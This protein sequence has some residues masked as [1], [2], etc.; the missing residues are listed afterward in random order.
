M[1]KMLEQ[2]KRY[3]REMF[4]VYSDD[5]FLNLWGTT[6]DADGDDYT[7]IYIWELREL[8]DK[9]ADYM[10]TLDKY[11]IFQTEESIS[12]F[13]LMGVDALGEVKNIE[14]ANNIAKSMVT[15]MRTRLSMNGVEH[16]LADEEVVSEA[17]I[18]DGDMPKTYVL[19]QEDGYSEGDLSSKVVA[20][21]KYESKL[22]TLCDDRVR[23]I[24]STSRFVGF[25]EREGIVGAYRQVVDEIRKLRITW[26]IE[27][28]LE[29]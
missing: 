29:V 21:S 11:H 16:P 15:A 18:V 28:V 20:S 27:E 2:Y 17:V 7:L 6:R 5:L 12:N 13:L 1:S 14:G 9:F 25:Q 24:K 23:R 4:N 8:A 3:Y 10:C 19:I 22:K 26:R